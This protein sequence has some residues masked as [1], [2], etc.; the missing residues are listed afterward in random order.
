ML[1][2]MYVSFVNYYDPCLREDDGYSLH[3]TVECA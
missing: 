3:V 2:L 1:E